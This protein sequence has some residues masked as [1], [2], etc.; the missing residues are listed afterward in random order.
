MENFDLFLERNKDISFI[1]YKTYVVSEETPKTSP[2]FTLSESIQPIHED[3]IKA[4]HSVLEL[5]EE[6]TEINQ[7]FGM[8]RE[9][10]P[11]YLFVFHERNEWDSIQSSL[12]KRCQ[13]YMKTLWDYIIQRYGHE[14]VTAHAC[15]SMITSRYVNYLFKPGQTLVQRKGNQYI[16][17]VARSWARLVKSSR[18]G[19]RNAAEVSQ[20][21]PNMFTFNRKNTLNKMGN[22]EIIIQEWSIDAWNWVFDGGF[23]RQKGVLKF[24]IRASANAKEIMSTR[25]E[26]MESVSDIASG[27]HSTPITEH[28]LPATY[29]HNVG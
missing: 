26:A 12:S 2:K 5:K 27:E 17:W 10:H 25:S 18:E 6:Y 14:Y 9:L 15:I 8:T 21:E 1:V 22:G 24:Y 28:D 19:Q 4:I 20:E 11:P 13:K 16:G 7:G 29:K 3:L 23:L